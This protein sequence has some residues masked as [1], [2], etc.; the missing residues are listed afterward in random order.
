MVGRQLQF[1]LPGGGSVRL[2]PQR[3]QEMAGANN[4]VHQAA[5]SSGEGQVRQLADYLEEAARFAKHSPTRGSPHRVFGEKF[6]TRK[7]S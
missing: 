2:E 3:Q 6:Q 5:V 4:A 1:D 7:L